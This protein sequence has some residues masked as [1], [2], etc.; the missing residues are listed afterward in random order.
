[1]ID[2]IPDFRIRLKRNPK[3]NQVVFATDV[4]SVFDIAWYTLARMITDFGPLE[5]DGRE[6]DLSN[7]TLVTCPCCGEAL[8]EGTNV[9]SVA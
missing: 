3:N 7:G 2:I 5:A 8:S 1:M 4:N 9:S 6:R